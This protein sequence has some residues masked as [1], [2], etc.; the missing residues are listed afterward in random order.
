MGKV[1]CVPAVGGEH[2]CCWYCWH[3]CYCWH[4]YSL[5]LL[6]RLVFIGVDASAV[7]ASPQV[8]VV[9][10]AAVDRAVTDF[11]PAVEIPGVLLCL[12]SLLLLLFIL[13]LTFPSAIVVANVSGCR[14]PCKWCCRHTVLATL[15]LLDVPAIA[16]VP[17]VAIV[18]HC[19]RVTILLQ[20]SSLLLLNWKI[21]NFT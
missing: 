19:W 16:K 17:A 12:Q 2:I 21:N 18:L 7:L 10:C 4:P 11:L 6:I 3:Q 8:L 14:C 20:L 5:L 9:S 13:L 15:L 1:S